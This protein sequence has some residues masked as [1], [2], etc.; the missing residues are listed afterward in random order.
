MFSINESSISTGYKRYSKKGSLVKNGK[1]VDD[2]EV[3]VDN[4]SKFQFADHAIFV[5]V[6]AEFL[7]LSK[8]FG[9]GE[10]RL[11][12]C[13]MYHVKG[14]SGIVTLPMDTLVE[15]L[16]LKEQMVRVHLRKL[17]KKG[18]IQKTY[19]KDVFEI[20]PNLFFNGSRLR[21]INKQMKSKE[22]T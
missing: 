6:Y 7:H 5:K 2:V 22:I 17:I 16:G 15:W 3:Y 12:M 1:V 19:Q 4:G 13:I 11:C 8:S 10:F 14:G 18:V 21:L 9:L 20:N